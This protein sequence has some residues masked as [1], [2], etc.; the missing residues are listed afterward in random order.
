MS[1]VKKM[2]SSKIIKAESERLGFYACGVAEARPVSAEHTAFFSD[3]IQRGGH[4]GMK[5]LEGH[6]DKRFDPTQLVEGCRSIV[7]VALNYYPAEL[8]PEDQPQIAWYAYGQDYHDVMRKKLQE[9]FE[10]IRRAHPDVP[11]SGRCFCDTAPVLERYWAWQCG[12]GWLGRNKQLI[13]PQAGST[14]FLGEVFLTCESDAYDSPMQSKCG[15]CTRCI[16]HCPVHALSE[17]RGL[18]ARRCLSYLTIENRGEIPAEAAE[19][20]SPCFYGCDRC[21]QAC[22]HMRY[23][24]PTAEPAFAPKAELLRMTSADWQNLTEESYQRLF[25]G[26]AVKRA[27]FSGLRRN[28]AAMAEADGDNHGSL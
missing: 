1:E 21:Q 9:L 6:A 20:M 10:A 3:W 2:L 8:I 14:F 5:Y 17:E 19:K 23:A 15:S 18:D 26:S 13:I 11:L 22:P 27:K 16:N 4:A 24:S 7:S 28:I 25:K 12:L